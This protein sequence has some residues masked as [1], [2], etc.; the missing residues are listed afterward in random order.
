M[1]PEIRPTSVC[2]CVHLCVVHSACVC[3][4]FP[5]TGKKMQSFLKISTLLNCLCLSK[6]QAG[7][8]RVNMS[9]VYNYSLVSSKIQQ[10]ITTDDSQMNHC[11]QR[12]EDY[13][14]VSLQ[15]KR[16]Y[17]YMSVEIGVI[18]SAFL[19]QKG[20]DGRTQQTMN[21]WLHGSVAPTSRDALEKHTSL[22]MSLSQ[23]AF[24]VTR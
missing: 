10:I 24:C 4:H 15:G 22:H 1:L 6:K 5:C 20:L 14:H 8:R 19:C 2:M 3:G 11:I 17:S 16:K 12:E 18:C 7:I 21:I 9:T 23:M 13:Q